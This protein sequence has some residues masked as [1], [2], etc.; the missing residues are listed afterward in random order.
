M[1]RPAPH[2]FQQLRARNPPGIESVLQLTMFEVVGVSPMPDPI[3]EPPARAYLVAGVRSLQPGRRVAL[4]V[5]FR[6][7]GRGSAASPL[8]CTQYSAPAWWV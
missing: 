7:Q 6:S 1:V 3:P 2:R 8:T 4:G 5:S